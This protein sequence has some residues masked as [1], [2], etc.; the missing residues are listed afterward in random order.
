MPT[1]R[2][3]QKQNKPKNTQN[4]F[5]SY[6]PLKHVFMDSIIQEHQSVNGIPIKD[7]DIEHK[8]NNGVET[9][10]G[11]YNDKPIYIIRTGAEQNKIPHKKTNK[12]RKKRIRR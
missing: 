1:K 11:H 12:K 10:Q 5:S 9:I 7:V 2:K 8:Y 3:R 6:P 4:M